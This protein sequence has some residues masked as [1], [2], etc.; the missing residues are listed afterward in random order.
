MGLEPDE[1]AEYQRHGGIGSGGVA[2][3][4]RVVALLGVLAGLTALQIPVWRDDVALWGAAVRWNTGSP[5]PRLNYA[6]ALRVAGQAES[7]AVWLERTAEVLEGY[8]QAE[9]YRQAIRIQFTLIESTGAYVCD[10]AR[11]QSLCY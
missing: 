9:A 2:V 3:K 11:R 10:S 1:P 8:P 5:R 7:A 4:I 6:I